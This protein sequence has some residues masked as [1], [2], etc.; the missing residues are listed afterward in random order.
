MRMVGAMR[1]RNS[2]WVRE[3]HSGRQGSNK[4]YR[5]CVCG[6]RAGKEREKET[7]T[8]VSSRGYGESTV[9]TTVAQTSPPTQAH[10][11]EQTVAQGLSRCHLV[12][13]VGEK[14][15]RA[16]NERGVLLSRGCGLIGEPM[17]RE[18]LHADWQPGDDALV[19]CEAGH[20]RCLPLLD[21]NDL[22]EGARGY[23]NMG[24]GGWRGG[25][26]GRS[27]ENEGRSESMS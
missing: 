22:L 18:L 25:G 23:A 9:M 16:L 24:K 26:V 10:T 3:M 8:N 17:A 21:E 12:W 14:A 1:E 2:V 5:V 27:A 13:G 7:L 15:H 19:V 6:G 4:H 20:A 11:P